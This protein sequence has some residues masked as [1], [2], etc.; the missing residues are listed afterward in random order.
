MLCTLLLI[1][2]YEAPPPQDLDFNLQALSTDWAFNFSTWELNAI[3]RKIALGLLAPQRFM[4]EKQRADFVLKYLDAINE[5]KRL[6]Q[7]IERAY[8]DPEIADPDTTTQEQQAALTRLR[9]AMA[10]QGLIAEAILGEQ[11]SI[12]M[13]QNGFGILGQVFPP[14]SG[15]FTPLPYMLVISPRNHIESVYQ[16]ALVTGLTAVEQSSIEEAIESA[17]PDYSAY[18]TSIGGLAAYPAMLLENSSI[19]WVADVMSH[20]W[21]HHNLTPYPLNL[22]Y[23]RSA[24]T[25]TIN[26]TTASLMGEWAGQEIIIQFYT[27]LLGRN[28]SLPDMLILP[29][30]EEQADELHFDF[31]NE[32]HHTRVIVDQMLAEGKLEEA[33]WYMELQRRYIVAQGYRIRRLN[34][35]YFAFHGAYA[36]TPGAS[37]EDPIGPAVRQL[38]A[39]SAT[40]K[41]FIR[42]IA[43]VTTLFELESI[44][45]LSKF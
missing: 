41:E 42:A 37:G 21:T 45:E 25:R 17:L 1:L 18:I 26:E 4:E 8:T 22:N 5:A 23:T 24:E 30:Q 34:Q 44:L 40:P 3:V 15:A 16:R 39:R 33:K 27:P 9:D 29:E 28:K 32:M 31:Q 20:E 6:T 36:S 43:P 10:R 11:V 7:E 12:I 2:H 13:T 35:A 38:W 14:V 19:D